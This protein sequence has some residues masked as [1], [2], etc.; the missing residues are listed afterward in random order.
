MKV[1]HRKLTEKEIEQLKENYCYSDNWSLIEV[2]EGFSPEYVRSVNFSGIVSLGVFEKTFIREGGVPIH[3]GILRATLHNCSVGDNVYIADIRNYIANYDIEDNCFIQNVT[4][5]V[6]SGK[7]SFGNGIKAAVLDETGAREVTI[8]DKLSSHQAYVHALYRYKPD[9]INKLESVIDTY[10]QCKESDRGFIG[11]N[12]SIRDSRTIKNVRISENTIIEGATILE[13]GSICGNKQASVRIGSDVIAEDFI[14]MSGSN[15]T[16]GAKLQRCFVG[17][18]CKISSGFSAVDSLFFANCHMAN[19][20]ACALFAGPYTVS[21]HK[22]SLLI[23]CMFSFMNAGSGSNQSNH[24]YKRGP[25]HYGIGERG[26]KLASNAYLALPA[27]IGPFTMVMGKHY[28]HF[29]T[30]MFPFSYLVENRGNTSL[31]PAVNMPTVGTLRDSR[32][33][34]ARDTRKDGN[35]LDNLSFNMLNPYVCGRILEAIRILNELLDESD[36]DIYEYNDC[37]I[38]VSAITRALKIYNLVL[39][40]YYGDILIENSGLKAEFMDSG[41]GE[42][43]DLGGLIA[44]KLEINEILA[45]IS[46]LDQLNKSLK[47]LESK[48]HSLEWSWVKSR[49]KDLSPNDLM[50]RWLK[51]TSELNKMIIKDAAK[52]FDNVFKVSYGVDGT[53][54]EKMLDFEIVK[55]PDEHNF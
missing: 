3:S 48:T 46:D 17:Q 53:N 16:N 38:T 18:G 24:M 28:K 26:L 10:I 21:H 12:T 41:I 49:V 1:T 22:P 27:K 51:A 29:D 55:G 33:W 9:V 45:N 8:H 37:Q 15:V 5:I 32:K 23:G 44:P 35:K 39:D 20:E 36:K 47:D 30:S 43:I 40:K 14:I 7:T 6:V 25:I 4:T 19:G 31:I 50:D 11:R 42:W 34:P 13:N 54:E 52:E 2:K